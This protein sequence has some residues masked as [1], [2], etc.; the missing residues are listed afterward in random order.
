MKRLVKLV[1][2]L[3]VR[4]GDLLHDGLLRILG[5]IP[6][7]R[8]VVLYYHEV[9]AH[10]RNRFARQMDLVL[11]SSVVVRADTTGPLE[12]GRRYCVITFDDG[13]VSVLENALPELEAR[14]IPATFFIPTGCFDQA[15]MWVK[16]PDAP[17]RR[18]RVLS[19]TQLARLRS[20][21]LIT[22]GSHTV[23][24]PRLAQLEETR[25][26]RELMESRVVLEEILGRPVSLLGFP[27]GS[28][29]DRVLALARQCG[30]QR[31]FTVQPRLAFGQPDEYSTGRM[32]VGLSDTPLEFKLRLLGA[33]RWMAISARAKSW[34]RSSASG[35]A[36]TALKTQ[37]QN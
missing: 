34:L 11:Q 7:A 13:F 25:I 1:V 36:T 28:F 15:P 19:V 20:H 23:T 32:A 6:P 27:H 5:R 35:P 26:T 4:G 31:V 21:H 33:Y 24:H 16:N 12:P 9:D 30:Y 2:S 3:L 14:G 29:D 8:C 18:Q 17:A 37:A 10:Q 22:I